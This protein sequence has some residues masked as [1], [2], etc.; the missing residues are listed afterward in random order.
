MFIHGSVCP[1][2]FSLFPCVDNVKV[3]QVITF[4]FF[5]FLD[6]ICFEREE[7]IIFNLCYSGNLLEANMIILYHLYFAIRVWPV[8]NIFSLLKILLKML[9][10]AVK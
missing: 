8:L 2:Y 3:T 10:S 9:S 7:I 1:E 6:A 5:S 4:F